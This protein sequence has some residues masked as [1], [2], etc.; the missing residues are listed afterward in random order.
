MFVIWYFELP[1]SLHLLRKRVHTLIMRTEKDRCWSTAKYH[2]VKRFSWPRQ[3]SS[4]QLHLSWGSCFNMVTLEYSVCTVVLVLTMDVRN[5][6]LCLVFSLLWVIA[7]F[8]CVLQYREKSNSTN[9]LISSSQ[10]PRGRRVFLKRCWCFSWVLVLSIV[11]DHQSDRKS[12]QSAL[13]KFR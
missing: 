12:V 4:Y 2:T 5:W 13:Q 6:C 3:V 7:I 8:L 11:A 10:F 9:F 1:L